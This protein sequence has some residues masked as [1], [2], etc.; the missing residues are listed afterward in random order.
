M[1]AKSGLQQT[2]RES[3]ANILSLVG[4]IVI[5]F[6]QQENG[7]LLI[8]HKIVLVLESDKSY[9]I[10]YNKFIWRRLL[11]LRFWFSEPRPVDFF[12]QFPDGTFPPVF[13]TVD[14]CKIRPI[15]SVLF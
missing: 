3:A 4:L 7:E 2:T 11:Y 12:A 10:F 14:F 9:F 8:K 6:F 1:T 13:C 5:F 15:I